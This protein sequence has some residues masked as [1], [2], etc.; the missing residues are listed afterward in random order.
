MGVIKPTIHLSMLDTSILK[1]LF[2]RLGHIAT[3]AIEWFASKYMIL[4]YDR[5]PFQFAGHKYE[6]L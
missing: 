5:Y 4:N 2:T 3:F 1:V 6:T